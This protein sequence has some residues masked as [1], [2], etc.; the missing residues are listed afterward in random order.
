MEIRII[1]VNEFRNKRNVNSSSECYN[2]KPY[3][4]QRQF[5]TMQTINARGRPFTY[6]SDLI[7]NEVVKVHKGELLAETESLTE[8]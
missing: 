5:G 4:R 3:A 2:P 1:F 8:V 6:L 7:F